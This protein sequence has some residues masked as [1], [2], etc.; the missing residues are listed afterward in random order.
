[1]LVEIEQYINWVRRR[2]PG[3][4]TWKNYNSDLRLFVRA[5]GGCTPEQITFR[6]VDRFVALQ[7]E[8]GLKPTTINRRLAAVISFYNFLSEDNCELVC[9]VIPR[10]HRLREPQR[11]PG[12]AASASRRSSSTGTKWPATG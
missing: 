6:D 12:R 2:N 3:T 5:V 7:L 1:M 11:L 9:P 10:R 4:C 8:R